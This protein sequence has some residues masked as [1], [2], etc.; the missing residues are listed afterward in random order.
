MDMPIGTMPGIG[1]GLAMVVAAIWRFSALSQRLVAVEAAIVEMKAA[2]I[3]N[4]DRIYAQLDRIETKISKLQEGKRE[5]VG[6]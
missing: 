4:L 5:S 1:G 6:I 2:E 3:R